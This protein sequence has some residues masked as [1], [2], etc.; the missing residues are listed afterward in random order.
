MKKA[1]FTFG[2]FNPPTTGHEKLIKKVSSEASKLSADYFI[3]ASKSQNAKKNP[4]DYSTKI[5]YMKSMFQSHSKNIIKNASINT[6]FDAA[7]LLYKMGYKEVSMVVGGDRVSEFD[8]TLNKYNGVKGRHGFYDFSGGLKIISAGDRDPDAEGV[9]GM[10]A[11]KMRAA[12]AGNDYSS[13]ETGLPSNFRDGKKLFKSVRKGMKL[14]NTELGHFLQSDLGNFQTFLEEVDFENLEFID[15]FDIVESFSN[16]ECLE[17]RESPVMSFSDFMCEKVSQKQIDDLEKFADKLLKKYNI[18]VEF[19]RHF[20]DRI[21][22]DRNTP[23]IK[24]SELQKVFK[25]IKSNKGNKIKS[26]SDHQAVITDI[27]SYLNIP[28]VIDVRGDETILTAKT[29]MRKKD[30]KSSNQVLKYEDIN[31]L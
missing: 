25:K 29:I 27:N 22:D 30:F 11:S 19:T 1:V 26:L 7:S 9:S 13:F 14:E 12:A 21:N 17:L 5:S 18:D 31:K 6:A 4:L 2:R 16:S 20:V 24:I 8:K 23:E 3:F 15:D 28:V 10:S